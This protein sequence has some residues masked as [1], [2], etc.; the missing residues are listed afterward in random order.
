MFVVLITAPHSRLYS[1]LSSVAIIM[2]SLSS[3]RTGLNR[4]GLKASTSV[5]TPMGGRPNRSKIFSDTCTGHLNL[6]DNAEHIF[7]QLPL[8]T[9]RPLPS[10]PFAPKN[11]V[12]THSQPFPSTVSNRQLRLLPSLP[13][14]RTSSSSVSP[15]GIL[16][17]SPSSSTTTNEDIRRDR[18]PTIYEVPSRPVRPLP[19]PSNSRP[20]VRRKSGDNST[21]L[22]FT[23]L[24]YDS[25]DPL[26]SPLHSPVE[27][28]QRTSN[29]FCPSRSPSRISWDDERWRGSSD[30][31]SSINDSSRVSSFAKTD[32]STREDDVY[33][34]T[35]TAYEPK[36]H[37]VDAQADDEDD[38]PVD[39]SWTLRNNTLI[40]QRARDVHF[41]KWSVEKNGRRITEQDYEM[42]R[43]I[44]R[45]L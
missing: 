31:E 40:R 16:Y 26:Y 25:P 42:I 30:W 45:S 15:I 24:S 1:K 43:D 36:V 39:Y 33:Y 23:E 4:P 14:S 13:S 2:A 7:T 34:P 27:D 17:P 29:T 32:A 11:S 28:F 8:Q 5:A 22:P 18:L 12:S 35:G 9:V 10:V 37:I 6:V 21:T 41:A 20:S 38:M 3:S 19:I 44:L